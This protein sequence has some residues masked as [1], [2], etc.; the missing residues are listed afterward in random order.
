MRVAMYYS[1][2][3]VRLEEM[4]KPS[5][6]PGEIVMRVEASGICGSDVMEWY[7]VDRVPLVLGHEVS[8]VVAEVGKGVKRYKKGDRIVAAHHVPCGSCVNCKSG[9]ETVCDTMRKT[10]FHPGGFSEYIRLP[11]INVKKGIFPIP[12]GVSF[13][14]ATFTEPLACVLRGQRIAGVKKRNAV[15][16]VGSG[17][18]GIL[19]INLAKFHGAKV[20]A[21]DISDF[22]LAAAKRFG[23]DEVIN[24]ADDVSRRAAEMNGGMPADV[25]IVC[26]GA[27]KAIEDAFKSVRRG[28]TVLF[29]AAT[30]KDVTIPFSINETFWRTEVTL[31][32]SYAG[33]P[34]EH[35]QALK[36][37]KAKKLKIRE[38]ITHKLPLSETLE[39]LRLVTNARDSLKVIVEPQK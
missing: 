23:A 12:E 31:V 15:L 28:G 8:G 36:L 37:I 1:N 2:N 25:V 21:T 22:R 9:H 16:V 11:K 13:E 34:D 24:G 38:M 39:G 32:S 5:P 18:A 33:S 3:D 7:R 27:P 10:T 17:I 20:I 14:E 30:N 29:F 6:G 19:H 35:R 26:A 4:S